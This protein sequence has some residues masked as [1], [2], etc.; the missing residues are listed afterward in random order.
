MSKLDKLCNILHNLVKELYGKR[1]DSQRN[2][3]D[4]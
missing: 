2:L 1:K 3:E 4:L